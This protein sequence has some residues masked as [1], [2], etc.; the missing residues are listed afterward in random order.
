[1]TPKVLD[2]SHHNTISS[3]D[4]IRAAGIAG[5][6]HKATQGTGYVDPMYGRRRQAAIDAGLLWGAYHF[7]TGDD[8]IAQIGHFLD[9]AKP[10]NNTLIA[11][12]HEPNNGDE[13]DLDGCKSFLEK[14]EEQLGRKAVLYS[15]NLIK[16]QL[17]SDQDEF[18]GSHRLWIAQYG[19][20]AKIPPAWGAWWLWQFSES[21]SVDGAGGK[22]DLNAY[23]G[24]DEDLATEWAS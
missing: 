11:L 17:G 12:D 7:A 23:N 6:I 24:S 22:L 19:P 1:M 15:G 2:I 13:L 3:F 18:L 14:I 20:V 8:V 21:G 9:N 5:V 10:E 16:E 4:R